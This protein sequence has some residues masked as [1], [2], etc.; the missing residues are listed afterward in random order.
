MALLK[1]VLPFDDFD[2]YLCGPPPFMQSLYQGLTALG[3]RE[4]RIRYESFGPATVLTSDAPKEPAA[5]TGASSGE[6]VAVHFAASGVD[7]EWSPDKGTLLDLAEASGLA[8]AYSCRSGICGTCAT[9]I[10]CGGVHYLDDPTAPRA[11]DEVLICCST[12]RP[13]AGTAT[14]GENRGV[15]LDL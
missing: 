2:F 6:P 7:A 5:S 15:V 8:P 1:R 3:V 12:P 9:R 10:R 4:E 14:C 13:S 11:D